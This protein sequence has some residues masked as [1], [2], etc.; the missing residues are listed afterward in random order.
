M[1]GTVHVRAMRQ[2]TLRHREL[3]TVGRVLKGHPLSDVYRI[4]ISAPPKQKFGDFELILV[5]RP[6]QSRHFRGLLTTVHILQGLLPVALAEPD[7][8]TA[9]ICFAVLGKPC[10]RIRKVS[11]GGF[12]ISTAKLHPS[13]KIQS[14]KIS[15]M[16][17]QKDIQILDGIRQSLGLD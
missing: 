12:H 13:A 16:M 11:V 8:R 2:Q 17:L 3:M 6:E 5:N 4:G 15:R 7:R 10:D 14:F 1:A 9:E